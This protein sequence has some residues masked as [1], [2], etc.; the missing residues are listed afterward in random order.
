MPTG[1]KGWRNAA[2]LLVLTT[3]NAAAAN[4][5]VTPDITL[6]ETYTDN[7][8]LSTPRRHDF[9]TEVTPGIRVEGRSP[10]LT[11][12][13]RYSPSAI[14]YARNSGENDIA[15][16][17]SAFGRLEAVEKFFFVEADGNISQNFVSPF[18]PRPAELTTITPNRT[19]TRTFGLSPNVRGQFGGGV[20]YELRNRNTWTTTDSD[21]LGDVQTTQWAGRIASP[22]RL[23]GWALGYDDS[24][25]RHE[26]FTDRPDQESRLYRGRLYYQPD[27]SWRFSASAGR[28]QNNFALQEERKNNIYGAGVSW[29]PTQRTVA[30]FEYERRYFGA[31]RLARFT[32]RTRLTAWNLGYSRTATSFQQ[33]LL[34]LPP[35][36]TAALLDAIF[37][38]R[39][40]DPDQRRAAV[41]QFQRATGTPAFLTNSLAFFTQQIF[42]REALE[43]SVGILGARNSITFTAFRSEN[44]PL[45]ADSGIALQDAFLLGSKIEQRGFGL[46]GEHRLT[47][48]TSVGASATRIYSSQEEPAGLDSRND[49]L[50]LTLT[51][52]LSPKTTTFA[53][54]STTRFS[55]SDASLANQDANSIFVALNHRF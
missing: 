22:V 23:F 19:E 21:E 26:R 18:A 12:S 30:D 11:A 2:A 4:W 7:I 49:F 25:I 34:R 40:A 24:K 39:I 41:E 10:R 36:D 47:P 1:A 5:S 44:T 28:E 13:L 16:S 33:E 42:L 3:A 55:S 20:N 29:R 51:H 27:V 17:L 38:A 31:S 8:F 35:G 48:F 32:H 50:A 45:S 53:G 6:R 43:A 37:A 52:T 46:R 15:N 9:V 54:V 14:F